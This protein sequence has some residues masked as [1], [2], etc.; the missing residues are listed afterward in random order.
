[1]LVDRVVDVFLKEHFLQYRDYCS[2]TL[3]NPVNPA[4]MYYTHIMEDEQDDD[5]TI[6]GIRRK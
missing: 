5:L 3:E 1:V 6:L 4:Y 2:F